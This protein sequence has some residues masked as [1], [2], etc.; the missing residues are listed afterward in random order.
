MYMDCI[1]GVFAVVSS[2][3]RLI[4]LSV[5]LLFRSTFKNANINAFSLS[6]LIC[7]WSTSRWQQDW[8]LTSENVLFFVFLKIIRTA[9]H[10]WSYLEERCHRAL[11]GCS[12]ETSLQEDRHWLRPK[13]PPTLTQSTTGGEESGLGLAFSFNLKTPQINNNQDQN[14]LTFIS[15]YYLNMIKVTFYILR[16]KI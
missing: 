13:P 14:V 6:E 10:L 16:V 15:V 3:Q 7:V 5:I 8:S 9:H 2:G 4:H 11:H 1:C 12:V